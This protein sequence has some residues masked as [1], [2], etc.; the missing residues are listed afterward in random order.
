MS[1][2]SEYPQ[3][4]IPY[5]IKYNS[6][7]EYVNYRLDN[8]PNEIY[9]VIHSDH[10]LWVTICITCAGNPQC[11]KPDGAIPRQVHAVVSFDLNHAFL[12]NKLWSLLVFTN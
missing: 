9:D 2:E 6:P 1:S 7:Y 4:G 10:I 11:P 8:F 3:H 12:T 5:A